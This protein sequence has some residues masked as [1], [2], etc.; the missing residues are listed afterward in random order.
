MGVDQDRRSLRDI[1]M[2]SEEGF[3]RRPVTSDVRN[4]FSVER[5]QDFLLW[6]LD[7]DFDFFVR[8]HMH[9]VRIALDVGRVIKNATGS[10]PDDARQDRWGILTYGLTIRELDHLGPV[11]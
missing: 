5:H 11:L 6:N 7:L 8:V 10:R 4:P 1:L 2:I 3:K 9:D